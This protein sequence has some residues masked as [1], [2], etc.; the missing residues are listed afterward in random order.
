[1]SRTHAIRKK[2]DAKLTI[3]VPES[4]LDDLRALKE[5][6]MQSTGDL[7]N[8]LIEVELQKQSI[9]VSEGRRLLREKKERANRIKSG[10]ATE[11]EPF[12]DARKDPNQLAREHVNKI[13][14]RVERDSC[15]PRRF[16]ITG[17]QKAAGLP[18]TGEGE[19]EARKLTAMV[20]EDLKRESRII[21]WEIM[22]RI[23]DGWE[24]AFFQLP[25]KSRRGKK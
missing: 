3:L 10:L 17:L 18:L 15:S 5:V 20:L 9:A 6:T 4:T 11:D 8:N 13:L 2:R 7:I 22:P 19:I 24:W 23:E 21:S 16:A 1:M 14:E 12:M 25:R